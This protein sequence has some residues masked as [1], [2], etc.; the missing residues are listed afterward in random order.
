MGLDRLVDRDTRR[1]QRQ[2]TAVAAS[3]FVG[4]AVMGGLT[5]AAVTARNE[6]R[7]QQAQA[8]GLI[9]FMLGDVRKTLEPV[10]KL[11]ALGAIGD[12]AMGY[13][14]AQETRRL[15]ADSLGRRARTL[16]L[17][18]EVA[19]L[20]GDS[21]AALKSFREA[22]LSTSELLKRWPNDPQR[23]FD[24]AQSA[25]WVGY[26]A[27]RRGQ[28]DEAARRFREYKVLADRLVALNSASD[29]WQAEVGYANRNLGVVLL[30]DGDAKGAA[31]AFG[32]ELATH[33]VLVGRAPQDSARSA[34]LGQ[35]Y[36]WSGD[37]QFR[38]GNFEAAMADRVA[39]RHV[40]QRLMA[41]TPADAA[42]MTALSS[43]RMAVARIF[44]Q[45][46]KLQDAIAELRIASQDAESLLQLD[47]ANMSSRERV[48][49]IQILRGEVELQAGQYA[50]AA[51]SA[52][53]AE[54]LAGVLAQKDPTMIDWVGRDLGGAR[55]LRMRVSAQIASNRGELLDA[56]AG[57]KEEFSRLAALAKRRPRDLHLAE[58]A[59]G[60][61]ILAGDRA[62]LSGD[63]FAAREL[64]GGGARTL[65]WA[66][67][68]NPGLGS[69]VRVLRELLE[70]RQSAAVPESTDSIKWM[71][72]YNW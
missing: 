18:G 38:L 27:L 32:R 65:E 15:S 16:H 36:A 11:E 69:T 41:H 19:D 63:P 2:L 5:V 50:A 33:L 1:R 60:A 10:G 57:A 62:A 47:P 49:L 71:H 54:A 46:G 56:V 13:Y 61:A 39:E 68:H 25:Y 48:A 26:I 14:A 40:Y 55:V 6:A 59:A 4:M 28:N 44:V 34:E 17:L 67:T 30:D 8:E 7:A 66:E 45:Q 35:A 29:A 22:S 53:A 12:R 3:G 58:A 64:W 20:R 37:A 42:T 9:E 31:E 70:Q 43:N 23:I 52:K 24:H 51:E 21:A 72:H